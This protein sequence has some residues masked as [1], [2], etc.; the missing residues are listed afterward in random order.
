MCST[1]PTRA[2]EKVSVGERPLARSACV[3]TA[4]NRSPCCSSITKPATLRPAVP[5]GFELVQ[6]ELD[7]LL[8]VRFADGPG[9]PTE[10]VEGEKKATVAGV[11]P[12]DVTRAPP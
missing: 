9:P 4:S 11:L 8:L 5:V 2:G 10:L 6:E 12:A 1:D 3:A 7:A